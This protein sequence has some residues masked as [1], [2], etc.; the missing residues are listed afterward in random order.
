MKYSTISLQCAMFF[1]SSSRCGAGWIS[2]SDQRSFFSFWEHG[3]NWHLG[4][5]CIILVSLWNKWQTASADVVLQSEKSTSKVCRAGFGI[6]K[7]THTKTI[8][9]LTLTWTGKQACSSHR[10]LRLGDLRLVG[11]IS[12]VV[13]NLQAQGWSR[14][15]SSWHHSR[16]LS[17]RRSMAVLDQQAP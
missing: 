7:D 14:G 16:S 9:F 8:S 15:R 11:G 13:S 2:S 4:N 10:K 5:D 17:T 6:T 3:S 1:N 12:A